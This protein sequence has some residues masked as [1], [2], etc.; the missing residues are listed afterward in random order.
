MT[1]LAVRQSIQAAVV[2]A[3][4]QPE[5]AVI[6]GSS[7]GI[8]ADPIVKLSV[9]SDTPEIPVRETLTGTGDLS[10]ALDQYR[11]LS[12]QILVETV[13][14]LHA[15][16]AL[17]VLVQTGLGL[18]TLAAEAALV[19]CVLLEAGGIRAH[20]Y[21]TDGRIVHAWSFD[22]RFRALYSFADPD[23]VGTIESVA[24]T[25]TTT[26]PAMTIITE[27]P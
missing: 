11:V 6:W 12:V 7:A 1:V 2:I 20:Q 13:N 8:C 3:S 5:G 4:G 14:D 18:E 22:A 9:V 16:D 15:S 25:G 23:T 10:R 26:G 19:D 17:D 27:V 24:V 21:R